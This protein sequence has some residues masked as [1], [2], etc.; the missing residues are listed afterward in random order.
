M[1]IFG[2]ISML[3]LWGVAKLHRFPKVRETSM[4]APN[5]KRSNVEFSKPH[6]IHGTIVYIQPHF[7]HKKINRSCTVKICHTQSSYGKETSADFFWRFHKFDTCPDI[8][9][10]FFLRS[11]FLRK[12]A[13]QSCPMASRGVHLQ[14]WRVSP[15]SKGKAAKKPQPGPSKWFVIGSEF[16]IPY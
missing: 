15:V 12:L 7:C 13:A 6:T 10:F 14:G 4:K 16:S 1:V 11:Q 3:N 9:D 2:T 5:E 8:I